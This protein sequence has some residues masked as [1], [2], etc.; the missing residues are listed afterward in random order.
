MVTDDDVT[1]N[2]LVA[3]TETTLKCNPPKVN[4]VNMSNKEIQ[5]HLQDEAQQPSLLLA[6]KTIYA[7]VEIQNC[8]TEYNHIT[9]VG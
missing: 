6:S 8:Q 7:N 4:Q 3:I 5:V 9:N 1:N 2:D